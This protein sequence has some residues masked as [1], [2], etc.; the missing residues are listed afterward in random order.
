MSEPPYNRRRAHLGRDTYSSYV[1]NVTPHK[2]RRDTRRQA[3]RA[4][5]RCTGS[6]NYHR[7]NEPISYATMRPGTPMLAF[8]E[9]KTILKDLLQLQMKGMKQAQEQ[10]LVNLTRKLLVPDLLTFILGPE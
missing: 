5:R 8:D 7:C 2:A 1:G 9:A 4:I 3:P 6:L 10:T